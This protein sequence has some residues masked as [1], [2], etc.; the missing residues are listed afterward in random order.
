MNTI[1]TDVPVVYTDRQTAY[2]IDDPELVAEFKSVKAPLGAFRYN[3]ASLRDRKSPFGTQFIL[4]FKNAAGDLELW[5]IEKTAFSMKWSESYVDFS[6]FEKVRKEL[7]KVRHRP[8]PC[9]K[10]VQARKTDKKAKTEPLYPGISN[11]GTPKPFDIKNIKTGV[12]YVSK[13]IFE[14]FSKV[15]KDI[16]KCEPAIF[17]DGKPVLSGL[18]QDHPLSENFD[19]LEQVAG[20]AKHTSEADLLWFDLEEDGQV[21]LRSGLGNGRYQPNLIVA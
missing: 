7:F 15:L 21:V 3:T 9:P 16:K 1:K 6:R 18:Y 10:A 11:A 4:Q 19:G 14:A 20:L 8:K 5:A 13:E 12:K 17:L 2:L